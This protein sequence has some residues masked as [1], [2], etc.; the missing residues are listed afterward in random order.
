[1]VAEVTLATV[2]AGVVA[3]GTAVAPLYHWYFIGTVPTT[4]VLRLT[5]PP[6]KTDRPC[7]FWEMEGAMVGAAPEPAGANR[8]ARGWR[9]FPR[10]GG[11][12]AGKHATQR[13]AEPS[14]AVEDAHRRS[15]ARRPARRSHAFDRGIAGART[16][17]AGL[18]PRQARMTSW[19]GNVRCAVVY[20]DLDYHPL[21]V[22]GLRWR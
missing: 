19:H 16:R 22:T 18:A 8:V 9:D 21:G 11:G 3:P 2:S 17:I 7:G 1:M 14:C 4:T 15:G 6:L 20:N 10:G 13:T 12:G 5:V